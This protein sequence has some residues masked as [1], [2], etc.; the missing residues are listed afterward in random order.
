MVLGYLNT[1]HKLNQSSV[2]TWPQKFPCLR[3]LACTNYSNFTVQTIRNFSQGFPAV[4]DLTHC[5]NP[6]A[7]FALLQETHRDIHAWPHLATL[8]LSSP[9]TLSVTTAEISK[10]LRVR[11]NMEYP[12]EKILLRPGKYQTFDLG[13]LKSLAQ[14]ELGESEWP[15]PFS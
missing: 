10:L 15:D 4:V 12:T 8:A 3:T 2:V 1:N 9:R 5:G 14:I 6:Q 11:S 7:V 13:E